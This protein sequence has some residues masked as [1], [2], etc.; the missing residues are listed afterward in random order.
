VIKSPYP[1]PV[2]AIDPGGTTGFAVLT[3]DGQLQTMTFKTIRGSLPP[4]K[5]VMFT[6]EPFFKFMRAVDWHLIIIENFVAD[7][8]VSAFGLYTIQLV[9]AIKMFGFMTSTPVY[10]QMPQHRYSS[11]KQMEEVLKGRSVVI[12]ERDA[13]MHLLAFLEKGPPVS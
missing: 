7:N 8:M 4:K 11:K 3:P 13:T 12:H 6:P 5:K 10:V 9:G 1:G 2:C